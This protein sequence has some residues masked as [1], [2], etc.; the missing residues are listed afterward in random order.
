M[1]FA[2]WQ[3]RGEQELDSTST[4]AQYAAQLVRQFQAALAASYVS[5]KVHTSLRN[6][7]KVTFWTRRYG[8]QV[9]FAFLEYVKNEFVQKFAERSRTAQANSLDKAFG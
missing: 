7:L 4:P 1:P 8:R 5:G 6:L 3:T 2:W 9:P